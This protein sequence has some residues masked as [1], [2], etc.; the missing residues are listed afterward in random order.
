MTP[1]REVEAWGYVIPPNPQQAFNRDHWH[2]RRST[3]RRKL[4]P[5]IKTH[6]EHS[7]EGGIP[8]SRMRTACWAGRGAG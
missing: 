7:E 1:D 4:F 3:P 5:T 6:N 2:P 8:M